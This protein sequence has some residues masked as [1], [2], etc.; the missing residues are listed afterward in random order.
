MEFPDRRDIHGISAFINKDDIRSNVD[1]EEIEKKIVSGNLFV[2]NEEAEKS[3]KYLKEQ[4]ELT[5]QS[6]M[7]S[8]F[9]QLVQEQT[10]T[11]MLSEVN[12]EYVFKTVSEAKVAQKKE[13]PAR[14]LIVVLSTVFGG[15]FGCILVILRR[16]NLSSKI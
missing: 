9:Y 15:F 10:K 14:A 7:K 8:I 6:E 2:D 13:R 5:K 3:I 12:D 16:E 1:L 11:L 4:I